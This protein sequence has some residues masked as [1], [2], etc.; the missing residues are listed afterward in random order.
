VRIVA[1]P[2]ICL[3]LLGALSCGARQPTA[4][5]SQPTRAEIARASVRTPAEIAARSTPSVVSVRTEQSLG[6]GFVVS[7]DGLIATNLHVIAGNSEITV[8][9]SDHREFQVVEIWNGDRQRDLVIMR[10]QAKKL[11]VIPLGNSDEI[12]AGDSIVAIGHP[13]GLED[14][15]SNG[16]VSAVRK[17]DKGLTVLQISAPIAPGS[18]GGPIFNDHGE[19]IGVAT[20]I[21]LGGQNINF[22]VPISYLK[23]LLKKPAA[24]NLATFAAATAERSAKADGRRNVPALSVRILDGCS[25]G[26]IELM[27]KALGDAIDIGAALYDD[28]NFA[29]CYHIYEGASSETAVSGPP[30]HSPTVES[31]PPGSPIRASKRG[32]CATP[33]TGCSMSSGD[34]VR[35]AADLRRYPPRRRGATCRRAART[36][37]DAD[38]ERATLRRYLMIPAAKAASASFSRKDCVRPEPDATRASTF[39]SSPTSVISMSPTSLPS[40]VITW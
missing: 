4:T 6:T 16:L 37:V 17:L 28:G 18:S 7:P 13:L 8:T 10:I 32:P 2:L 12:R 15:V 29:G 23:E 36:D 31:A 19:V 21:M 33:S 9:L 5:S 38:A 3:S 1:W 30:K 27:M 22:G 11:P 35:K 26:T 34:T 40:P 20:A 14:T 25:R 24:V 39:R